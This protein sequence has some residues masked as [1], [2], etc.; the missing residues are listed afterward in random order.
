MC[1]FKNIWWSFSFLFDLIFFDSLFFCFFA[2]IPDH[3]NYNYRQTWWANKCQHQ[4]DNQ[5]IFFNFNFIN[6][7]NLLNIICWLVL[8]H[9][10]DYLN[11]I[12]WLNLRFY[13]NTWFR[14][15]LLRFHL[16]LFWFLIWLKILLWLQLLL[17]IRLIL[18]ILWLSI[19]WLRWRWRIKR[20][21]RSGW[22]LRL[23]WAPRIWWVLWSGWIRRV[24]WTCWFI[25]L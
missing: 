2:A 25:R 3:Q 24:W 16:R 1:T 19:I 18:R 5:M 4:N 13:L 17:I 22:P 10:F 14:I 11:W 7:I 9:N 20:F 23:G 6:F 21:L 12:L 8:S 15:Y